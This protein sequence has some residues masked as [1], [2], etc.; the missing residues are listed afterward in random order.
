M[1][2]YRKTRIEAAQLTRE[3]KQKMQYQ[4]VF[5]SPFDFLWFVGVDVAVVVVVIVAVVVALVVA[6]VIA[7]IVVPPS[8]SA[9]PQAHLMRMAHSTSLMRHDLAISS[10][11]NWPAMLHN[12]SPRRNYLGK[13]N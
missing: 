11:V 5:S 2:T 10:S 6:V 12:D 9:M 7:V 4:V 1:A 3:R 8:G 13:E